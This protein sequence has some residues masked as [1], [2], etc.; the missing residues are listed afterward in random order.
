MKSLGILFAALSAGFRPIMN[1]L[2]QQERAALL[3]SR[4]PQFAPPKRGTM[5]RL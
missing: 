3:S 1:R 2:L 4:G 5:E